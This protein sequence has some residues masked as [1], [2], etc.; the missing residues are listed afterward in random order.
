M[1][2]QGVLYIVCQPWEL[3]ERVKVYYIYSVSAVGAKERVKVYYIYS[4][5]AVGAKERVKVYY[6]YIYI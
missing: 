1:Y 2:Y 6:I 4:V 5:S 3:E